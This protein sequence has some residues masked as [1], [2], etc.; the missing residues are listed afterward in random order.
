MI[1]QPDRVDHPNDRRLLRVNAFR[2]SPPKIFGATALDPERREFRTV[3]AKCFPVPSQLETKF[4][5]QNL[6]FDGDL[7]RL[8]LLW[9]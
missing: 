1:R 5:R 9:Q 4:S 2:S 3:P 7:G 6:V 8:L